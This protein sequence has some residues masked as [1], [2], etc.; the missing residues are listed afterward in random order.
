M[1]IFKFWKPI[2]TE[3]D[4]HDGAQKVQLKREGCFLQNS[5]RVLKVPKKPWREWP[6]DSLCDIP[7]SL[8]DQ[9]CT[10]GST[11]CHP[12]SDRCK[13]FVAMSHIL[14]CQSQRDVEA[15][16]KTSWR[17]SRHTQ[18]SRKPK[19]G[20]SV[21]LA[22]SQDMETRASSIWSKHVKAEII[23]YV[24]KD[25]SYTIR[26]CIQLLSACTCHILP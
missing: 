25:L 22:T 13:S 4:K 17:C 5:K 11:P 23:L 9:D 2:S 3:I 14:P 20:L 18:A 6:R 8:S 10:E 21:G 19:W 16:F 24:Q 12:R 7:H 15:M 1:K 26:M